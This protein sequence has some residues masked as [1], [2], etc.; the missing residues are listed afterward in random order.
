MGEHAG[1]QGP[2]RVLTRPCR[3][4]GPTGMER[5]PSRPSPLLIPTCAF[6]FFFAVMNHSCDHNIFPGSSALLLSPRTRG[7]SGRTRVGPSAVQYTRTR[8]RGTE[9][10]SLLHGL[11]YRCRSQLRPPLTG[12]PQLGWFKQDGGS[13]LFW[14]L[15]AGDWG[16]SVVRFL[17]R[18]DG[19]L[20]GES[21]HGRERD[22]KETDCLLFFFLRHQSHSQGLHP[23]T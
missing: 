12:V 17:G 6:F 22:T 7:W 21:S 15:E 16:A 20:L 3:L 11:C 10:R 4:H 14:R 23:L 5:Y 18:A 9:A 19:C 1:W 8:P 2:V 13:S